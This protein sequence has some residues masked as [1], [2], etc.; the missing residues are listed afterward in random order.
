PP[1][2]SHQP[3][4]QAK[5]GDL[6]ETFSRLDRSGCDPELVDLARRCLAGDPKER[7]AN[8]QAVAEAMTAYLA[9]V[10]ERLRRAQL[11]SARAVETRKRRRV[12]TVLLSL[13]A[14]GSVGAALWLRGERDS[15]RE[16][17]GRAVT[18]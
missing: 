7:P 9:G 17:E 1:F 14:I 18:S 11:A 2:A 13:M 4:E 15:A 3:L 8:G 5:L 12:L 16:A 6:G 10:Q